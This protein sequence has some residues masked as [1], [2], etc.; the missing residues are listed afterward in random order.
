MLEIENVTLEYLEKELATTR[1]ERT[2]LKGEDAD[3][4]IGDI[5]KETEL[6]IMNQI[7]LQR[8]RSTNT[9]REV[10]KHPFTTIATIATTILTE[11]AAESSRL[12]NALKA[13]RGEELVDNLSTTIS[14][15]ELSTYAKSAVI[16]QR[17]TKKLSK[18][19]PGMNSDTLLDEVTQVKELTDDTWD[20][21]LAITK[22]LIAYGCVSTNSTLNSSVDF[23]SNVFGLTPAG[24]HVAMLNFENSLWARVA[25]GGAWD[26]SGAS[27]ELDE[28]ENALKI[29]DGDLEVDGRDSFIDQKQ[30]IP[31]PQVEADALCSLLKRMTP[32]EL[33]GYVSSFISDDS[34]GGGGG[35]SIVDMFQRLTPLQ[36]Q[37]IQKSLGSMER[38]VD[39]Q[40][41]Y[42]VDETTRN[43]NL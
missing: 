36:Q 10:S 20:D 5:Y 31:K 13:A 2:K 23:E 25:M 27:A 19:V 16:L 8:T 17:Q 40:K 22:T 37:V 14:P 28:L 32:G 42:G 4:V 7:E 21:F 39:V 12:L 18:A 24:Q 34:R 3:E 29:F 15:G 35:S 41:L 43:C 26:V 33:A 1:A 38:L 30:V 6:D 9:E 11:S